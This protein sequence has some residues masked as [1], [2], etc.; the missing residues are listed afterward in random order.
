MTRKPQDTS[1]AT[2]TMQK[3]T[4][5][6]SP[7]EK[8][9]RVL[10]IE[11]NPD[12]A[13][14]LR[15]LVQTKDGQVDLQWVDRLP[16]ALDRLAGDSFDIALT[17][18]RLADRA[19]DD[20]FAEIHARFPHLPVVVLT[21]FDSQDAAIE[22]VRNG[23][24]DYLVKG[25]AKGP[26]I[27]RLIKYSIERQRLLND[28]EKHLKE[29][30]TLR[31]LI[32]VCSWCRKVHSHKGY[33]EKVEKFIEEQTDASFTH[34]ICPDCLARNEPEIFRQLEKQSPGLFTRK[35]AGRAD[36][37]VIRL[38]LIEDNPA[39][40]GLVREFAADSGDSPPQIS[41]ATRLAEAVEL[42]QQEAFDV[43]LA[44]LCLPDSQGI[45]TFI[46]IHTLVPEVPIIILT[47][48]SD[49][50]LAASAVRS[51]AQDYL[52]KGGID[53]ALLGKS[54]QYAIE[55]HKM[56]KELR[57]NLREVGKLQ[58][59]RENLLSAFAHDIKNAIIP[60]GLL[61]S[62]IIT[63][64]SR[65]AAGSIAPVR[66]GLL[67]AEN[68]LAEFIEFS[69][70][71]APEYQ[72]VKAPFD[73]EAVMQKQ[74]EAAR[75]KAEEKNIRL[76][77]GFLVSPPP[78]LQADAGMMQRVIANLL[79]NAIKYTPKGGAVNVSVRRALRSVLVQVQDTGI[80]I[81]ENHLPLL[82]EAFYRVPGGEKGSGLGLAIARTIIK[83][84]GGEIWANSAAG[85]GSTFN[86][87]LPLE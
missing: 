51:G 72:P 30:R 53:G 22:A 44:D 47:G 54:I 3:K 21:G 10:L 14:M 27:L 17:D 5:Q 24:Q 58:R 86:F 1:G 38:L 41:H 36:E 83:A 61:L 29:I 69:R 82:F 4:R 71:E 67:A 49:K 6:T 37:R 59:E 12:D 66:D 87:T 77:C 75:L 39:D 11:D 23:A 62:R 48:I 81:A 40:A 63:G 68:M 73:L 16:A 78:L 64:K 45:E 43:V 76:E 56:L 70:F 33:W 52:V 74:I 25:R 79:D 57:K 35:G 31:G 28:C 18:L 65:P 13:E 15:G 9:I 32:P 60:A 2:T 19:E 8:P 85:E 20:V 7:P 34:G 26:S 55:R 80:G 50:D 42:L 84:H 46:K